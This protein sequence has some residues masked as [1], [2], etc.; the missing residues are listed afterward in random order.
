MK[1]ARKRQRDQHKAER[2]R[3]TISM[4]LLQAQAQ[5]ETEEAGNCKSCSTMGWEQRGT[6]RYYYQKV[7]NGTRVRS[8][9]VGRG[10]IAQM[11]SQI[12]SSSAVLERLSRATNST[13]IHEYEKAEA[14]LDQTVE[15][16]RLFTQVALLT[17]GFHTHHRQWRRN[18]NAG[19]S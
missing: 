8:V 15:L 18:R 4:K 12:Q 9:Y 13:E 3:R 19:R 16:V 5:L 2:L 7:R 14:V 11:V 1:G 10:E 17:A 6:H